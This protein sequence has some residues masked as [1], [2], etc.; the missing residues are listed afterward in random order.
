VGIAAQRCFAVRRANLGS[1]LRC[2]PTRAFIFLLE[3][4]THA[5]SARSALAFLGT[6][7]AMLA[8]L[9]QQ[10]RQRGFRR[11]PAWHGSGPTG[12]AFGA[13]PPKGLHVSRHLL[14]KHL[15]APASNVRVCPE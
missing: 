8:S 14:S 11:A 7:R 12:M 2:S 4:F 15:H 10:K 5:S 1:G 3:V 9:E 6:A 13:F